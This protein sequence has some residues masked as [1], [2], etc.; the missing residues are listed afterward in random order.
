MIF[1]RAKPFE[2][3]EN[4]W[5]GQMECEIDNRRIDNLHNSVYI[6]H[7]NEIKPANAQS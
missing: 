3:W 4:T 7:G 6:Q 1:R 5:R 2:N